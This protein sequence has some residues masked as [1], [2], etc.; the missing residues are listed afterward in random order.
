MGRVSLNGKIVRVSHPSEPDRHFALFNDTENTLTGLLRVTSGFSG[1]C[2][3]GDEGLKEWGQL[4]VVTVVRDFPLFV[5][6]DPK[7]P[8]TKGAGDKGFHVELEWT[9]W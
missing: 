8:T 3:S 1:R 5:P 9:Y 2:S 4:C 7:V 6:P